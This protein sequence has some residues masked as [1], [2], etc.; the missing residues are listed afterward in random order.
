MNTT[1][2]FKEETT[3]GQK[4]LRIG[5]AEEF[6]SIKLQNKS[7]P[8]EDRRYF[9]KEKSLDPDQPDVLLIEVDRDEY[10]K[11]NKEN[12]MRCRNIKAAQRFT[13]MSME[14]VVQGIRTGKLEEAAL[15]KENPMFEEADTRVLLEELCDELRKWKPW[16][17]DMLHTYI[18]EGTEVCAT[19]FGEKY[20]F[21]KATSW[22]YVRQFEQKIKNFL[23]A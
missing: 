8:V 2:L 21:S 23:E 5:T 1:Y 20:G 18:Q 14:S 11:W 15:F 6:D 7:L 16:A 17:V 10:D 4:K 9:I 3:N 19:Q 12:V 13:M 22:R